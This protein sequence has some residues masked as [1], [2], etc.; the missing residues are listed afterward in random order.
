MD[1]SNI[2]EFHLGKR[3]LHFN[4]HGIRKMASNIISLI[5]R[6]QQLDYELDLSHKSNLITGNNEVICHSSM[7]HDE[8]EGVT[9]HIMPE[10]KLD[11]SFYDNHES[12]N[13]DLDFEPRRQYV[14]TRYPQYY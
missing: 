4:D 7:L 5:K 2:F 3:G 12:G 8:I 6:L 13:K 10:P 1:N 14:A 9:V 11:G